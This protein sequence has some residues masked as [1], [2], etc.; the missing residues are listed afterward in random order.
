[1][2]FVA[3]IFSK[4]ESGGIG[5]FLSSFLNIPMKLTCSLVLLFDCF[6]RYVFQIIFPR[7]GVFSDCL[8]RKKKKTRPV[9][10]IKIELSIINRDFCGDFPN[11]DTERYFALFSIFNRDRRSGSPSSIHSLPVHLKSSDLTHIQR[12]RHTDSHIGCTYL[13]V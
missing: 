5:I 9:F 13:Y 8:E 11:I 4:N 6:F 10:E 12:V 2:V 1:M 7:F 3:F